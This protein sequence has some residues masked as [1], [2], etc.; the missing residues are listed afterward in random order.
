MGSSPDLALGWSRV[1]ARG[2][3]S[4][5]VFW[6]GSGHQC[7]PFQGDP[8]RHWQLHSDSRYCYVAETQE[9]AEMSACLCSGCL[10]PAHTCSYSGPLPQTLGPSAR[11]PLEAG[12]SGSPSSK[13]LKLS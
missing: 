13:G 9:P 11:S 8:T 10:Q 12:P 4:Q 2:F 7:C 1:L 5:S 3:K 6:L